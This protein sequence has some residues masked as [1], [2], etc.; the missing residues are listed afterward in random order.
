[1]K[2]LQL[3]HRIPFPP[4]DGGNIAMYNICRSLLLQ[5]NEVKI[6]ALNTKK[7]FTDIRSLPEQFVNETNLE[8]IYIDTSV[9]K[10]QAFFNLFT[11]KSY[12]IIRFYSAEFEARLVELLGKEKYDIVQLESSFMLPYLSCI[13]TN[14][15]AKIVLRAHNVEHVIWER[16]YKSEKNFFRKNYLKLLTRRLKTFE[17]SHLNKLDAILPITFDDEKILRN[18]G[19]KI[20]VH[21]TPLGIDLK[22]YKVVSEEIPQW[23]LFHLGS[24][25][26][27]PNLEGIEWFLKNCWN[28]I[29]NEFPDLKLYLAGRGFPKHL[30]EAGY[31]NV[32]CEREISD[33]NQYMQRKRIMIVPLLSGSGMRVKIIQGMALQKTIISTTIGAEGI[34]CSDGEN[35]LIADTPQQFLEAV[36]RCLSDKIFAEEIGKSGRELV[37]KK[38][39]NEAIGKGLHGFYSNLRGN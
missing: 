32:I 30:V 34:E 11:T 5:G 10:L 28:P 4:T 23:S 24:M 12:N 6:L 14:S 25:D 18:L 36:N 33:S 13:R 20:P 8:S 1:V 31:P 38:Y 9:K 22:E 21:V 37:E 15:T 27:L 17:T 7:H 35:I 3:C 16:L 29:H 26:W 2:I 39:T 19:C